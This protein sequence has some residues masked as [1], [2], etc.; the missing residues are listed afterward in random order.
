MASVSH[1]SQIAAFLTWVAAMFASVRKTIIGQHNAAARHGGR[2]DLVLANPD[3]T[4]GII[5][6][7]RVIGS[8]VV[9]IA[10]TVI[11]VNEVLTVDAV[12]NS[13]GP[14]AGVIE[15]LETT[16]VAAMG[17]LV[18][19]LVVVAGRAIM[20]YMGGGDGF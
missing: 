6:E 5:R 11:V 8:A 13:S 19:G 12:N 2:D 17:L 18:V 14:F 16:G 1:Q 4:M 3:A 20:G 10:L 9:I 7:V 15:S